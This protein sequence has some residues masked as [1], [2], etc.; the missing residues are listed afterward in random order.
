MNHRDG[1]FEG[2]GGQ[3]IYYR[4]WAPEEP[5]RAVLMLVHNPA[6]Q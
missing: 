4:Y 2:A 1:S 3:S 6:V 5:A